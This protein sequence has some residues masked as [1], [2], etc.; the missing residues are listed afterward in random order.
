MSVSVVVVVVPACGMVN[1]DLCTGARLIIA[2]MQINVCDASVCVCVH[3][4]LKFVHSRV[5]V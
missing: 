2:Y 1:N 5:F 4:A 3:K